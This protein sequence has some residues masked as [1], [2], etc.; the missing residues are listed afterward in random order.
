MYIYLE[1]AKKHLNINKD[2][3]DDDMYIASLIQVA[4][5]IVEKDIDTRLA[6]LED[7][8]VL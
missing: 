1:D 8:E 3:L 5:E 2:F 6:D 4:E 7:E